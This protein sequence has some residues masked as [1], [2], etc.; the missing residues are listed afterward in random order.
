M[1][2]LKCFVCIGSDASNAVFP[3]DDDYL[4]ILAFITDTLVIK[5]FDHFHNLHLWH[6]NYKF[7]SIQKK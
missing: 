5:I 1:S 4:I 3:S 2:D 7:Q 6:G